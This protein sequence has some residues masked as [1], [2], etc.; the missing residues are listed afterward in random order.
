MTLPAFVF[1]QASDSLQMDDKPTGGISIAILLD[2]ANCSNG[3]ATDLQKLNAFHRNQSDWIHSVQGYYVSEQHDLFDQFMSLHGIQFPVVKNSPLVAYLN[4]LVTP[5]VLIFDARSGTILD[6]HQP[7]S[8]DVQ[9]STLF[10][11]KWVRL[12]NRYPLTRIIHINAK[13]M[14]EG[15]RSGFVSS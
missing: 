3:L 6:T 10:Y 15:R 14:F 9:K 12:M 13:S 7:I 11:D 1:G 2:P 8:D 4:H 5:L